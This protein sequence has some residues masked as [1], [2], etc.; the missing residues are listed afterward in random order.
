MKVDSKNLN[1]ALERILFEDTVHPMPHAAYGVHDRPGPTGE[2]D[3]EF[4]PT[5]HPD[6]PLKPTELMSSQLAS[7]RPPIEDEDYL[8]TS[9]SDLRGAASAIAG[10][11]PPDHVEKFYMRMKDL[12]ASAEEE[13]DADA[14]PKSKQ[15]RSEEEQEEMP[16]KAPL[17]KESR[18]AKIKRITEALNVLARA[19]KAKKRERRLNESLLWEVDLPPITRVP[20]GASGM[21]RQSTKVSRLAAAALEDSTPA[22]QATS[23]DDDTFELIARYLGFKSGASGARQYIKSLLNRLQSVLKDEEYEQGVDGLE[24][25]DALSERIATAFVD[26][27][28][29]ATEEMD[30]DEVEIYKTNTSILRK[31]FPEYAAFLGGLFKASQSEIQSNVEQYAKSRANNLLDKVISS[32]GVPNDQ[33]EVAKKSIIQTLLNQIKGEADRKPAT[34]I[35]RLVAAGLDQDTA[36]TIAEIA[37]SSIGGIA[38]DIKNTGFSLAGVANELYDEMISDYA[39]RS[40]SGKMSKIEKAAEDAFKQGGQANFEQIIDK[41]NMGL[42]NFERSDPPQDPYNFYVNFI[43]ELTRTIQY[44][45]ENDLEITSGIKDQIDDMKERMDADIGQYPELEE[46]VKPLDSILSTI[47]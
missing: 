34:I 23:S 30:P 22:S 15:V 21:R 8:P 31:D 17:K 25:V 39:V 36:A 29:V 20:Q 9:V 28:L 26:N 4:K 13:R 5:V 19:V 45:V 47:V 7:E 42:S 38:K 37:D 18:A 46:I 16:V 41:L 33:R 3:H 35:R 24:N 43:P 40:S 10:L 11:V 14:A 32:V 12:L 44:F 27:Y 1:R 2:A 6:L